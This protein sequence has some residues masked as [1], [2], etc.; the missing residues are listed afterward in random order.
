MIVVDAAAVPAHLAQ[1]IICM[2]C[3][4]GMITDARSRPSVY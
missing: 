4:L 1:V 2:K 3:A